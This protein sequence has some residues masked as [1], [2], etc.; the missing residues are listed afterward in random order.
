[1]LVNEAIY[2]K[3]TGADWHRASATALDIYPELPESP[4]S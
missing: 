3:V 1:M 4:T 2:R